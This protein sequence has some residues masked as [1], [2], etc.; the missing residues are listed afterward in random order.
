MTKPLP[1]FIEEMHAL[2]IAVTAALVDE[3]ESIAEQAVNYLHE[4]LAHFDGSEEYRSAIDRMAAKIAAEGL[5]LKYGAYLN[6]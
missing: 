6:V 1:N 4:V 2:C 5:D 3:P